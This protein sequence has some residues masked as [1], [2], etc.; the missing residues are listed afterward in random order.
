MSRETEKLFGRPGVSTSRPC[1][2]SIFAS[3]SLRL[4]LVDE[5]VFAVGV[6]SCRI[7]ISLKLGAEFDQAGGLTGGGLFEGWPSRGQGAGELILAEPELRLDPH[8]RVD[9]LP[10][11]G[12]VDESG[13]HREFVVGLAEPAADGSPGGGIAPAGDGA[14]RPNRPI[15]LTATGSPCLGL[16][17]ALLHR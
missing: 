15:H 14:Q 13:H 5:E 7:G 6:M 12:L 16:F 2:T 9:D 3:A 11:V 10:S 1:N 17:V 8:R 4:T